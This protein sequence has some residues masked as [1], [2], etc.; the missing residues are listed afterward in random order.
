LQS[1]FCLLGKAHVFLLSSP[2]H[3]HCHS[4]IIS[5]LCVADT[6]FLCKLTGESRWSQIGRHEKCVGL[7]QHIPLGFPLTAGGK[8][9]VQKDWYVCFFTSKEGNF[10]HFL[11][12]SLMTGLKSPFLPPPLISGKVSSSQLN[13]VFIW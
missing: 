8:R 2:G 9:E 6:E 5:S 3:L 10:F 13:N 7:V 11:K 1:K 4:L 12:S